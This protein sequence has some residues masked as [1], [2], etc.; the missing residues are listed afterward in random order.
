MEKEDP[1]LKIVRLSR[2]VKTAQEEGIRTGN[3]KAFDLAAAEF[4]TESKRW[5]EEDATRQLFEAQGQ[6]QPI[7][8]AASMAAGDVS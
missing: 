2:A 3:W 1:I 5:R 4:R 6:V 8:E 7:Q